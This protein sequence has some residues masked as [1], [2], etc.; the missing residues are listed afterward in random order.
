MSGLEVCQYIIFS[1]CLIPCG[2]CNCTSSLSCSTSF[3]NLLA[4]SQVDTSNG[5]TIVCWTSINFSTEYCTS[6]PPDGKRLPPQRWYGFSDGDLTAHCDLK[7]PAEYQ[8]VPAQTQWQRVNHFPMLCSVPRL[9][10][11]LKIPCLGNILACW[12][13]NLPSASITAG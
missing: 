10:L 4:L 9:S 7:L 3:T 6:L 8:I 2:R 5:T 13:T 1:Y 11:D 12:K